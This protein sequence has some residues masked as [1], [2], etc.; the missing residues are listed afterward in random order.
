MKHSFLSAIICFLT[1]NA[2]QTKKEEPQKP[3]VLFILADDL[4]YHD[5]S[6][7]GSSYYETPNIDRI[8]QEGAAFAH[9]YSACQVC[10]PSRGSI[11][12]GKSPVRQGITDYIGAPRSEEHTS[13]L[14]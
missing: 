4:G 9:G 7:T 8:A 5:L 2:C 6:C 1:L 13:E 3:N 12:T 10:S 14:Q 11:M